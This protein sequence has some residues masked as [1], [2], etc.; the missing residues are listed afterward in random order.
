MKIGEAISKILKENGIKKVVY[1]ERLGIPPQ[2]LNG[3]LNYRNMT[4]DIACE[5]LDKLNYRLVLLPDTVKLP[6][7]AIIV[8]GNKE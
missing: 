1:A 8:E 6:K 2:T 3:R 7:E 4:V 5:M